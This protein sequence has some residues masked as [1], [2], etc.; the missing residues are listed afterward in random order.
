MPIYCNSDAYECPASRCQAR[1]V[2]A[3]VYVSAPLHV[4]ARL[5]LLSA[6]HCLL[7]Q[8]SLLTFPLQR[9][10]LPVRIVRAFLV[11]EQKIVKKVLKQ[12]KEKAVSN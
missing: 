2:C 11:E 8:D 7:S 6:L 4:R 9:V 10:H 5:C 1:L 3:L 12:Q